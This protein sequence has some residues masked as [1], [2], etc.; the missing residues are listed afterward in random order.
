MSFNSEYLELRKKRKKQEEK[1]ENPIIISDVPM[2]TITSKNN[3]APEDF[4][5]RLTTSLPTVNID[6]ET[7]DN[8][9][10]FQGSKYFDDGY[11][12]GDVTKTILGTLG[13]VG[14][15]LVGSI[16]D[17]SEGLLNAGATVVGN[18][19]GIFGNDELKKETEYF[20]KEDKLDNDVGDLVEMLTG[21]NFDEKSV[22]GEKSD[23]LV[24]SA[25]QLGAT[26]AL[27][28]TGV[29]WWLTTGLTS[30]G[31]ETANALNQGATLEEATIS[32]LVTAGAEILT[33]KISGGIK[34]GGKTLDDALTKT[35]AANISKKVTR[36]LA[37]FGMDAVGEGAE[38]VLSGVM[39]AVGQKLTYADD[40]ELNELF[41]SED[42]WESFIGGAVLGGFSS[43]ANA[44]KS[45]VTGVDALSGLTTNE[46]AVFDKVYKDT[47]AEREKGGEKLTAKEKTKI[48]DDVLNKLEKGYI[49]TD[50]IESVLGGETYKQYQTE[51][52]NEKALQDEKTK[53]QNELKTLEE[54]SNT[55]GNAKKY[56]ATE[57]KLAEVESK[58]KEFHD[59]S[60]VS[61]LKGQLSNEVSELAKNSRLAESYNE[62]SR[63]SQ[64]FEADLSKYDEKQRSAVK[65]AIDSG[66]LNNTN[67][68]HEFVDLIAKLE[69]D[70]G[71]LFDFTN[72]EKLKGSM[73][74]IEG[75]EVAGYVQGKNIAINIDSSKAL[76]T[77]VG[78]EITHILEGTELYPV[79]Q[80]VVKVFAESKGE[81]NSKLQSITEMYD[82]MEGANIENELTAELVG[83]YLFSDTEFIKNL[84]AEQP[85]VFQKV[86]EEI[87]YLCKVATTGSK[88]LRQLEKVKKTFAEVYRQKNNTVTDNG[89]MYSLNANFPS[90][91]DSWDKI[92]PTIHFDIGTT[93]ETL[94]QI[95]LSDKKIV[96][97]SSKI[98]KIK[99]KH[100]EMT[101]TII[102]QVPEILESP[103]I[104]MQ[105]K[106]SSSRLTM[107]G[108]VYT[109]EN[110]PVLA[111]LELHPTKNNIAID[112]IKLAS[113]YGKDNAQNFI[114]SSKVLYVDKNKKRT[115]KWSQITRLQL[116]V[117][118]ELFSSN[119]SLSQDEPTVNNDSMQIDA[120]YAEAIEKGDAETAQK[121]V[122]DAAK[123]AGYNSPILYHGTKSFG[124]T[125]FDLQKMDDGR[126]IFLTSNNNIASTYSGVTGSRDVSD[127]YNKKIEQM[128]AKQVVD[129]LNALRTEDTEDNYKYSHYDLKK[130]N[131]LITTVNNGIDSLKEIVSFELQKSSDKDAKTYNQLLKLNDLLQKYKYDELSTPIY[132]LL[133][134][135]DVFSQNG[136]EISQ[137]EKNIRLFNKIRSL[138][139]LDGVIVEESFGGYSI[140][141]N[142][143]QEARDKLTV[144]S[145]T[146]NYA[147]Y[148]KLGKS[149]VVDCNGS[150]WNDITY[151]EEI[152]ESFK[153]FYPN[154][155]WQ[156]GTTR[157]VAEYAQSLGYDSVTFKNIRDN[158]GQNYNVEADEISDIYVVFNPENVKSA[159]MVTY[160]ENGEVIPLSE[161]FNEENKDMRYSL[162]DNTED[163]A[164]EMN[165]NIYG[166]DIKLEIDD[167]PIK[168]T[169]SAETTQSTDN[170]ELDIPDLFVKPKNIENEQTVVSDDVASVQQSAETTH[171]DLVEQMS[172]IM[173]ETP[174]SD[175]KEELP[176]YFVDSENKQET[177]LTRKVHHSNIIEGFKSVFKKE[178]IDLD[179]A[180]KAGRRHGEIF[181]DDNTPQRLLEKTFGYKAGKLLADLT[182]NKIAQNET[183]GIKWLNTITGKKGLLR[184]L[185]K[186]YNI[187]P[188]SKEDAAAHMYLEGFY[189][190]ESDEYV[191]YGDAELA[192]DF[193][194][195][196]VRENIR[197]FAKDPRVREFYDLSLNAIN[198]AR[199]RNAYEPIPRRDNYALHFRAMDDFFSRLGV[200][201]NPNDIKAKD[202]P[203]DL[204]GV[205]VD[206]KP[207]QPYFASAKHRIGVKTT[208]SLLGGM[209]R[210]ANSAK[211]Q[212]YHIDDI[213]NLRALR[214]YIADTFGQAKGLEGID[215]LPAGEAKERIEQVYSGH[216]SNFAKWLNEEA[217]HV[218]GKTALI[219]RAIPRRALQVLSKINGM[220]G[221]NQVGLNISS[222]LTNIIPVV[223]T[224]ARTNK[225][226]FV[227]AFSQTVLN[228]AR[229]RSGND[230]GF[231]EKS[232][233]MIRR[234]GAESFAKTPYQKA[235]DAGYAFMSAVDGVATELIAR[236]KYNEY[237]RKGM[238]E[239]KAHIETDKWVSRL[240]GDRSLGQ[241]PLLYNSKTYGL[242]TKYQLEVRNQLD[243]MFYDTLQ[244]AKE[245]YENIESN[246]E[247]NAKTA[248]K[249]TATLFEL[250]VAQHFFGTAFE[251]M[252][253]Y[254]PAFDII[255]VILT[256]CGYDDDE[257]S[258][259]TTL[260]NLEQAFFELLGDLPYS[261]LITGGGRI[262]ISSALPI[263][264]V[265][266]GK[267]QN[268]YD[269]SR[270]ERG[271]KALEALPYYL[272]PTGY[273]QIKKTIQGLS[274]FDDDLPIAGSYTDSENLRFTVDETMGEMLRAGLFGQ[275]SSKTA[276]QYFDEERAPLKEKQIQELIDLDIPIQDY[277]EIREGLSDLG[278]YAKL[279]EKGDYIGNLDLP[280]EKK[281]ILINNIADRDTPIDLRGFENYDDF[282]EFDFATRYPEKYA[283]LQE[284][285]ISV[286]EYNEKYKETAFLYTDDFSWA[287]NNPEGYVISKAV[288]DDV[289]QYKQY[290]SDL[291]SIEADKDRNGKSISGSKKKKKTA[292]INDLDIDRGAKLILFKSQYKSDDRYNSEIVDYLNSRED[293]T[294]DEIITILKELDFTVYDDGTVRW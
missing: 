108:E 207:G 209:E 140:E 178:G 281:N 125:E 162:N 100:S 121:L 255:E 73:F 18:V 139:V 179:K 133:H 181:Y 14:V 267:D 13:D 158:G 101:D 52:D 216:L 186:E 117:N 176:D 222:S 118:Y 211:N 75:K 49:S 137:L 97:D 248:A 263:Q 160:D 292:Y 234:K 225:Y 131:E 185:S 151:Y 242:F 112:E 288:T 219:D 62:K 146:G 124:F 61:Q 227:K 210:Y 87:K 76:N 8:R 82:G 269:L 247:K 98:I 249:Y 10:W 237:I 24:Q 259:D 37:K 214:N 253:G 236:T 199:T 165:N 110:K 127:T 232:P 280:V 144:R 156:K 68:T 129:E 148:A 188:Y 78:H 221:S 276:R 20:I 278:P 164:P 135:S 134:Y 143:L 106:N 60:K 28:M 43:G 113:A 56:E 183:E 70:K 147:L 50:T 84:S 240:M 291:N 4:K 190:N 111:V 233:V 142:S 256:A 168:E 203:T 122:E 260:D 35:L 80:D 195:R 171:D 273:G 66:I 224:F 250:A 5:P 283:V 174:K 130:T 116:P 123:K 38:E 96:W 31:G 206:L 166:E 26:A 243:S 177:K 86:Y 119:N 132:M 265:I 191:R 223:Q 175:A 218:A 228:T 42:A 126:C 65:R 153:K 197:L 59:N 208:Y 149:F 161:R 293:I 220:V 172:D 32:G 94:K 231:A 150:L 287:A 53:L 194:D 63:K 57:N 245:K 120:D 17:I 254:N 39:S 251:S 154:G 105:S 258:E 241:Q 136:K 193:P 16:G 289:L 45:S 77:V 184:K 138:D 104:V 85:G 83:E 41:S 217:N 284:Q 115:E 36:T 141:V 72:N 90:E 3:I 212:I 230:D 91:Y 21:L 244:E 19:A 54:A 128:T 275:Y 215:E 189:V 204:N 93:S 58:L 2:K 33:E 152:P 272:L 261:S 74:T 268:G 23:A 271:L 67:R 25:G 51:V 182:V 257:D 30:F 34:F 114:N 235:T 282:E 15:N 92:D 22:L 285:G 274:M 155:L 286:K 200:P 81:Y 229:R 55:I 246:L 99:S 290:T 46:K 262:P 252:A 95:G 44:V 239:Q 159:D 29:P 103:I 6:S 48:Y 169:T 109:T 277:W 238:S 64:A 102:K 170:T 180:L 213:Q 157:D 202:L 270:E 7:E 187:K 1:S 69:A 205:T 264:E 279:N 89:V 226:D 27:S 198:E 107:F 71:V 11:N 9:T 79:L 201:L 192:A 294:R 47:I 163:I 40:K 145:K 167:V 173:D 196:N 12:V 266:M 88:E